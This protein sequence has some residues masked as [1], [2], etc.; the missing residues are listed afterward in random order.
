MDDTTVFGVP[1]ASE[2]AAIV[3]YEADRFWADDHVDDRVDD[4]VPVA[5]R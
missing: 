5:A 1:C 4:V 3:R 2:S